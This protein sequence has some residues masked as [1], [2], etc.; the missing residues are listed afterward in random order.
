MDREQEES[1]LLRIT[2]QYV[3]EV[4]AGR[5]P[6]L[7]D[8]LARYPQYA[9]E[10]ADFV[11]YYH[12][13]EADVPAE[14]GAIPA[15]SE[16]FRIAID[17]A[18]E[19]VLGSESAPTN[20]MQTLLVTASKERLTLSQLASKLGLSIDIAAKLE[21]RKIKPSSLPGELYTR[22]SGA[23]QESLGALQ[24]YF[25]VPLEQV[26]PMQQVAE[27][28]AAYQVEREAGRQAQSFR[29][30]LEE[31]EQLSEEQKRDWYKA[32]KREGL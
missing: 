3:E 13:F 14:T 10:I 4:R 23:L 21:Q 25:E 7:S 32:L 24:A 9:D 6:V 2:E 15:L 8:Y 16:E 28:Q 26:V 22:L 30:A 5:T 31:S 29:E 11:A 18:Y 27:A 12:A 20:K 1:I 19:R 17:S